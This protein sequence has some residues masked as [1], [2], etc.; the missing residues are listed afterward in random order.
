MASGP[1]E[2]LR[3]VMFVFSD[4]DDNM[5]QTTSNSAVQAALQAG[6]RV[7]VVYAAITHIPQESRFFL[8]HLTEKTGGKR[9][10]LYGEKD[11]PVIAAS[12][13]QELTNLMAVT[14]ATNPLPGNQPRHIELK[15]E[16]KGVEISAPQW[17][18]L[19]N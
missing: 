13:N 15:C 17:I 11:T 7:Y 12:L 5:S 2:P 3:K 4:G 19:P 1:A 9:F 18:Y 6:V 16:R 8:K 10:V 14:Y